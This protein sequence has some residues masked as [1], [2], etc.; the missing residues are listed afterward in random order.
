MTM[1]REQRE[2]LIAAYRAGSDVVEEALAGT[3]H[4][5]LDARPE[6]D[7]WTAREVVH[8]LADTEMTSAVRLRRLIAEDDPEIVG[9]DEMEFSRRLYYDRP[10][11]ASLEAFRGACLSSADILDRLTEDQW[12]R[13]GTHTERG[14]YGVETWL[15]THA[16]HAHDHAEQI[17]GARASASGD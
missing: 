16:R 3:T 17:R 2:E 12:A 10:I 13:T 11:E 1:D 15:E 14:P 6:P 4:A 5:E 7:A 8:H 9:Y